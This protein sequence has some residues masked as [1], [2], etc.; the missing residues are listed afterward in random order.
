MGL[1][2][3]CLIEQLRSAGGPSPETRRSSDKLLAHTAQSV[4]G[5]FM[6]YK[7]LADSCLPTNKVGPRVKHRRRLDLHA[8]FRF[9]TDKVV[10]P[11]EPSHEF[12]ARQQRLRPV[13]FINSA[14]QDA[15]V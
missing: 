8:T 3:R 10:G 5:D 15:T 11:L 1:F 12:L 7:R 14:T 13:L 9:A 4:W 6:P 2:E